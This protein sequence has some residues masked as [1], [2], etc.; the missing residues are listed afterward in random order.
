LK[1]YSV[2]DVKWIWTIL[3]NTDPGLPDVADARQ[4][5]AGLTGI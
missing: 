1:K 2:L 4:W 3:P 5:L